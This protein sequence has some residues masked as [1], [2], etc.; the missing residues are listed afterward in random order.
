MICDY[1]CGRIGKY[2]FKNGKTCCMPKFNQCPTDIERR[3]SIL[4]SIDPNT[5][6]TPLQK[7]DQKLKETIDPE[8]G[9]SLMKLRNQKAGITRNTLNPE[10]GL[11][12][13]QMSQQSMLTDVDPTTGLNKKQSAALLAIERLK[14]QQDKES[15]LDRWTNS[16][17]K[18]K[19]SHVNRSFEKKQLSI[20]KR[21]RTMSTVNPDTGLTKYQSTGNKI[22]QTKTVIDPTT[23]L[24][25]AQVTAA[26]NLT[27]PKWLRGVGRGKA[28]TESMKLL[29]PLIDYAR[30]LNLKYYCGTDDSQEYFISI[31]GYPVKFY[32]FVI[33]ELKLI[34]EYH[35]EYWHP[36][37]DRL[38]E[39]EWAK[40]KIPITYRSA[41]EISTND[42]LKLKLANMRGFEVVYVWST[43]NIGLSIETIKALIDSKRQQV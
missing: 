15:G 22:R 40:W 39:D 13:N 3:K 30:Q 29:K 7:R 21:E 16:R 14:S 23:G 4:T 19:H 26:K 31:S 41:E 6:L 20:E 10:T 34:I 1:G 25:I 24:S 28:S 18:S 38:S 9:L 17:Q 33:P 8:S 36:N 42:Q 35:G 2:R 43:D 32:D 12:V 27:N 5:G 37:R 11:T